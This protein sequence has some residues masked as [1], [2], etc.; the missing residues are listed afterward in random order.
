MEGLLENVLLETKR[1]RIRA[2]APDDAPCLYENHLDNEVKKW[3]PYECYQDL[4]ETQEAIQFY[5][6]CVQQK[7]LPYVLAVELKA[8]GELIGD[9]GANEVEGKPGEVEIGYIIFKSYRGQGYA[10]ELLEAMT[11]YLSQTFGSSV[12]YGRVMHDNQASARVLE[13]SGYTF[14]TEEF[15][16][17]D[18]PYGKGMLVYKK[19]F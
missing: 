18:D 10:T 7:R 19:A 17:E 16:A 4:Q 13:K 12:L 8:T 15:G 5:R 2:F 3:F 9:S 14:V 6:D 1:L 11:T